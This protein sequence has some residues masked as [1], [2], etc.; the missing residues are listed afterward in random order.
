MAPAREVAEERTAPASAGR[1]R[2]PRTR[3][4]GWQDYPCVGGEDMLRGLG[5][6][7]KFGSPPRRRG[8]PTL[9]TEGGHLARHLIPFTPGED[10]HRTAPDTGLA[11]TADRHPDGGHRPPQ[12]G[13]PHAALPTRGRAAGGTRHDRGLR[14]PHPDAEPAERPTRSGERHPARSSRPGRHRGLPP[15]DA[16]NAAGRTATTR[17]CHLSYLGSPVDPAGSAGRTRGRRAS[18]PAVS[19]SQ[20]M[21]SARPARRQ[22]EC[23][24]APDYRPEHGARQV[25]AAGHRAARI[26]GRTV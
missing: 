17:A 1:T 2:T 13:G 22:A 8:G 16:L 20:P 15:C 12:E 10:H 3:S 9:C 7:G 14:Q 5:S 26:P 6:V 25:S 4:R 23:A 18:V 21:P 19:T 11:P 24:Y